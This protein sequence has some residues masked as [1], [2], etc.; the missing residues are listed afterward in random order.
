MLVNSRSRLAFQ[1]SGPDAAPLANVLGGGLTARDLQHLGAFEAYATLVH[2]GSPTPPVSL[3]TLPPLPPCGDARAARER[4]RA[5]WSRPIAEVE[6]AI[7]ARRQPAAS[8]LGGRRRR[9]P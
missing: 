7:L 1:T 4:S 6:T 2:R 5:Q 9:S 8:D 3:R